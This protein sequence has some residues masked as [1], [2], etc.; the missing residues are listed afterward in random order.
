MILYY[1][2]NKSIALIYTYLTDMQK[3]ASVHPIIS[4]IEK[5]N[6]NTY[7]VYETLRVGFI[8]FSFTYPVHIQAD[9]ST[10]CVTMKAKVFGMVEIEMMFRLFETLGQSPQDESMTKIEE[11]IKFKSLFPIASFVKSIFKT[12]HK[13]LFQNIEAA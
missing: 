2:L 6:E 4:K 13:K 8:P 7:L 9:E 12:Q 3:F 1:K 5:T 11:T 10:R